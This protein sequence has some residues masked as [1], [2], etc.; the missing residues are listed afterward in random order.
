MVYYK[1][2]LRVSRRVF[3]MFMNFIYSPKS[4]S[5]VVCL[6]LVMMRGRSLVPATWHGI[7]YPAAIAIIAFIAIMRVGRL[8]TEGPSKTKSVEYLKLE[9]ALVE[10][11]KQIAIKERIK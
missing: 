7:F 11:Q 1:P 2:R 3:A 8:I 9:G 6:I 4:S 5:L 10:R